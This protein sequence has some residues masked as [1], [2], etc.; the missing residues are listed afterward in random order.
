MCAMSPLLLLPLLAVLWLDQ[1]CA[2]DDPLQ[3]YI[4]EEL[5]PNTLIGNIVDTARLDNKFDPGTLQELRFKFLTKPKLGGDYFKIEPES[6][7]LR[8]TASIDRD[9]ICPLELECLIKFDVAVQPIQFFQII[10][11]QL[12]II[13]INDNPPEFPQRRI[14]HH[15]SESAVPGKSFVIPAAL[16]PDSGA[17]AIQEYELYPVN[18]KFELQV[19]RTADG[20][21][22]LRL[23]LKEQLDREKTGSYEVQVMAYDGG[24]PPKSGSIV[25]DVEVQDANDNDPKFEKESYEVYIKENLPIGTTVLRVKARDDDKGPNG[26][27]VYEFSKSS[28]LEF[29]NVFGINE[30]TGDIFIKGNLDYEDDFIYLLSIVANDRGPDSLSAHVTVVIHVQDSNDNP[31][32]I[33]VNTLTSDATAQVAE[34]A[35]PGTFVAHISVVDG[36]S[37]NNGKFTCSIDNPNFKLEKLYLT[38]FKVVTA[39]RFDRERKSH[40]ELALTCRDK[41]QQ[42][43]VSIAPIH[44]TITDENDHSP[45]FLQDSYTVIVKENNMVGMSILEVS[46]IDDD[47]GKNGRIEYKLSDNAK[48]MLSV[49]IGSGVVTARIIFDHEESETFAFHVIAEDQGDP[50][51]RSQVPVQMSI[52]DLDD[53]RPEFLQNTY[54]FGTFENQ[55]PGMLVGK[56]SATD[57]D[58]PPFNKFSYRLDRNSGVSDVFEIGSKTGKIITKR[59]LDREKQ[60]MYEM[61]AIV[62]PDDDPTYSSTTTVSIY[63]ADKNDNSPRFV[64]PAE[65]NDTV[66]VSSHATMGYVFARL[67]AI[68]RDRNT[69]AKLSYHIKNGNHDNMFT[70]DPGAGALSVN[71]DLSTLDMEEFHLQVVVKDGGEPQR[72]DYWT[73]KVVVRKDIPFAQ[74]SRGQ[75]LSGDNLVIVLAFILATIFVAIIIICAIIFIVKRKN[76]QEEPLREKEMQKMLPPTSDEHRDLP[77]GGKT[78]PNN[79]VTTDDIERMKKTMYS[80]KGIGSEGSASDVNLNG[81]CL[82]ADDSQVSSQLNIMN[83]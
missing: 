7:I 33:S 23:V 49:D 15:I 69:N 57:K 17:N 66:E 52:L 80:S 10:K 32:Q 79:Y 73:L 64:F 4:L 72:S 74:A 83:R 45:V 24:I 9:V 71:A 50:P 39:R 56:I 13:D 77:P 61:K 31:P 18:R 25:I 43:Q 16:D 37:G 65:G 27:V 5:P 3:Y 38:E 8:T 6:G 35:D 19:K 68:D 75:L 55:E 70:I 47:V 20:A 12:E 30:D 41:G 62:S 53:E 11:V 82:Y 14:T 63:V 42:P 36:D 26:K 59:K 58:S 2:A 22:D 28:E 76:R 21:T 51:R 54:A 78:A 29:G 44:V 67:R 46:A 48:D 1:R 34:N 81:S 40:Y 60:D